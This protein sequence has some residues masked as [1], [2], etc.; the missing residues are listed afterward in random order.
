[1]TDLELQIEIIEAFLEDDE[2]AYPYRYFEEKTGE[3]RERIKKIMDELRINAGMVGYVRGLIN[4]DGEVVG[5]GFELTLRATQ[6][7]IREW[8]AE[9]RKMRDEELEPKSLGERTR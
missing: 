6:L 9:L 8:L 2:Y 1:M 5:S 7:S 4:E 3:P